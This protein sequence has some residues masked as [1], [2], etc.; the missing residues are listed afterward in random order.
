MCLVTKYLCIILTFFLPVSC[1]SLEVSVSLNWCLWM[2]SEQTHA[3]R[4][5]SSGGEAALQCKHTD[6]MDVLHLKLSCLRYFVR[7]PPFRDVTL[8]TFCGMDTIAR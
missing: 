3:G 6:F 5:V 1:D 8:S 2:T 4:L 7:R